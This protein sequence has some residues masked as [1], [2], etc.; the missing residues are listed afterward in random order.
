MR[1]LVGTKVALVGGLVGVGMLLGMPVVLAA[2]VH[3]GGRTSPAIIP[4]GG[5]CGQYQFDVVVPA[6]GVAYTLAHTAS[7]GVGAIVEMVSHGYPQY[8]LGLPLWGQFATA[9][10]ASLGNAATLH[11]LV[12]NGPLWSNQG[13]SRSVRLGVHEQLDGYAGVSIQAQGT[14]YP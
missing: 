1:W 9:S 8:S 14:Y 12:C 4:G 10:Y 3:A 7:S 6:G 5:Q 11:D 13:G 2:S